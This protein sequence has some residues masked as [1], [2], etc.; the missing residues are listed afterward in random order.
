[1]S[2]HLDIKQTDFDETFNNRKREWS[3]VLQGEDV[4]SNIS[5]TVDNGRFYIYLNE[6]ELNVHNMTDGFVEIVFAQPVPFTGEMISYQKDY[7]SDVRN[8]TPLD[9]VF[10]EIVKIDI[11]VDNGR[12]YVSLNGIE[13]KVNHMTDGVFT[14]GNQKD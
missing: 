5:V 10:S 7:D 2:I 4:I 1:M 3:D 6:I 14:I 12:F 11:G 8:K 13:I 9:S